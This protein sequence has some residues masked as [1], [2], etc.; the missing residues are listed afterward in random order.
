[1]CLAKSQYYMNKILWKT[2]F[3][4]WKERRRKILYLSATQWIN[5]LMLWTKFFEKLSLCNEGKERTKKKDFLFFFFFPFLPS[6]L[7]REVFCCNQSK[8]DSL[9]KIKTSQSI[10]K[11]FLK[12]ISQPTHQSKMQVAIFISKN[13]IE[14]CFL[15]PF[16]SI[17]AKLEMAKKIH[18][19]GENFHMQHVCIPSCHTGRNSFNLFQISCSANTTDTDSGVS[20]VSKD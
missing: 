7:P 9:D 12:T 17:L 18:L 16:F 19:Q 13:P 1:M 2:I 11:E 20:G 5:S 15:K 14:L 4:Q 10:W 8:K 3:V 6:K